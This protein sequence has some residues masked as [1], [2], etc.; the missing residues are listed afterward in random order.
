MSPVRATVLP[1]SLDLQLRT[2]QLSRY[3]RSKRKT[4][5]AA[6]VQMAAAEDQARQNSPAQMGGAAGAAGRHGRP[7]G[8]AAAT[9][10]LQAR[11]DA[12]L[13][14]A[15]PSPATEALL[16]ELA[17]QGECAAV[18]AVWDAL[19]ANGV[20]PNEAAWAALDRLHSRGKGKIPVGRL[21][22]PF[23][24]GGARALAPGR[25]LHKI[26]K[27]RRLSARSDAAKSVLGPATQWVAAERAKGRKFNGVTTAKARISLAKELRAALSLPSLEVARGLVTKLKQKKLL[28]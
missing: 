6:G 24:A 9:L 18:I 28:L 1:L 26:M 22:V 4:R 8:A 16:V 19:K 10:G 20:A 27:G 21:T 13:R 25:R 11:L 17:A 12:A 14:P 2:L 23:K 15:A 5:A 7:A 3:A